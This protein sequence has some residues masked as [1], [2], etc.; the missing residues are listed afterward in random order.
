M[1][2]QPIPKKQPFRA[3]VREVMDPFEG[4]PES[5]WLSLIVDLFILFCIVASCA[6]ILLEFLYPD[7]ADLLLRCEYGFVSIF[8]VE[9]FLRWY[10][11]PNRRMYPFEFYALIDLAAI[12]PTL[13]T[14]NGQLMLLRML[15]GFRLLRLLRLIEFFRYRFLIYR[16]INLFCTWFGSF[17]YQ[18]RLQ[19]LRNLFLWVTLAWILGANLLYFTELLNGIE[20]GPYSLYW[21]T[22]WHIIIVLI[23]GIED[24]EPVSLLGRVEVTLLLIVGIIIVGMLTAEIVSILVKRIQRIGMVAVKPPN[25]RLSNHIVILG[26]N[27]HLDHILHQL[28]AALKGKYYF[29][30]V[31]PDAENHKISDPLIYKRVLARSGDPVQMK[32]LDESDVDSALRVAVLAAD[33]NLPPQSIDNKTLMI[34]LAVACRRKGIPMVVELKTRESMSY[35]KQLPG[36]DFVVGGRYVEYL[37]CQ[38][39]LN[40][41]VT[42][43]YYELMNF[44]REDNELYTIPLPS[45]LVG[46]SF[47][48]AQLHFLD[49]D[50][51]SIVLIGVDRSPPDAPHT[52][53]WINSGVTQKGL[54]NTNLILNAGDNLIVMAYERPF[55]PAFEKEEIWS[56]KIIYRI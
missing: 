34:T 43:I 18:Y 23:S 52:R 39:V 7:R 32:I 16:S 42:E 31:S 44:I 28:Y 9:Y 45:H 40:P 20:D 14:L 27:S 38:A 3:R 29:L 8:V 33:E 25:A 15:R 17:N 6:I 5:T 36:I 35:A 2:S 19:Q 21:Q 1:K 37:A 4:G 13:L 56:G 30:I 53:F 54:S 49:Y 12:L 26:T 55:H 24:K 48:D 41:G 22:Y 47:Q 46:K 11:A 50:Q 10:S 51:E